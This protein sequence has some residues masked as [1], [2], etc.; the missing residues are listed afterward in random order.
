MSSKSRKSLKLFKVKDKSFSEIALVR[1][2]VLAVNVA[3]APSAAVT[4]EIA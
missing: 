4:P 3:V 1:S 2:P